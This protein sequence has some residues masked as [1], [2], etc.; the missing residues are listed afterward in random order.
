M[1]DGRTERRDARRLEDVPERRGGLAA[2]RR[3]ARKAGARL[4]PPAVVLAAL[5]AAWHVVVVHYDVPAVVLPSPIEVGATLAETYPTLLS[6]AAVTAATAGIGLFAGTVVGAGLAFAML[7]SR[8]A[9]STLLPYVVALRIAPVIA[10]APLLF[11]WFGRGIPAR[12]LVV[13]TLTVFPITIATLDGLRGTPESYLDLA[14]TVDASPTAAFVRVR[15]PAAAP[16]VFAGLKIAA[17]LSVIGAI[18]AEFVTLNAGLGYRVF[19]TAAYLRTAET[20]AAL[21]VLSTLG[22]AFYLVPVGLE[23]ALWH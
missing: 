4:L 20:Y 8:R 12:S 17:T 16:S 13:T 11:L 23:R 1:I 6:D 5:L 19:E 15:V 2:G 18:V 10:I 9:A 14:R 7:G 21:V 3:L 22:I